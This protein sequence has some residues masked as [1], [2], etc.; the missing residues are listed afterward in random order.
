MISNELFR[1]GSRILKLRISLEI[2]AFDQTGS[3]RQSSIMTLRRMADILRQC[4]SINRGKAY[5]NLEK[6]NE[7]IRDLSLAI[8][9]DNSL[10]NA[11]RNRSTAYFKTQQWEK[12][13]ADAEK[14]LSKDPSWNEGYLIRGTSQYQL[15]NYEAAIEDLKKAE[16]RSAGDENSQ[17]FIADSY[18]ALEDF[19][20]AGIYFDKVV[21]ENADD[22]EAWEKL[23]ISLYKNGQYANAV[24]ALDKCNTTEALGY[25]GMGLYQTGK[26]EES[27]KILNKI[28]TTDFEDVD[29]FRFLA[30]MQ[31]NKELYSQAMSSYSKIIKR[32]PES[33]EAYIGRARAN[34]GLA[35]AVSVHEDLQTAMKLD[36]SPSTRRTCGLIYFDAENFT[37]VVNTLI[38]LEN[39]DEKVNNALAIS[40]Y[41]EQRFKESIPYYEALKDKRGQTLSLAIAYYTT[42]DMA[43]AFKWFRKTEAEIS[44]PSDYTTF[45]AHAAF[46]QKQFAKALSL[47]EGKSSD[48]PKVARMRALSAYELK[49]FDLALEE[50]KKAVLDSA[51]ARVGG[52]SAHKLGKS[53]DVIAFL[54]DQSA[55]IEILEPLASAYILTSQLPSAIDSYT[56]LIALNSESAQYYTSRGELYVELEQTDAAIKDLGKALEINPSLKDA[57][58][59]RGRLAFE[60]EQYEIAIEDL[61]IVKDQDK[62]G[63][64]YYMLGMAY[65][66]SGEKGTAIPALLKADD[67]GFRNVELT[68]ILGTY[69]FD[70][71]EYE[72]AADR[73]THAIQNGNDDPS[74][75][76]MRGRSYYALENYEMAVGDFE[77]IEADTYELAYEYGHSLY[78][79]KNFDKASSLLKKATVLNPNDADAFYYL[80]NAK[81]RLESFKDA[82]KAYESAATNGMSTA[83]LFNNLGKS[84][85]KLDD[86][87]GSLPYFGKAL[88]IDP[89]FEKARLNRGQ[90]YFELNKYEE[91]IDDL[92]E[93]DETEYPEIN[94]MLGESFFQA[95]RLS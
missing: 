4:Y 71:A 86:K 49:Q 45:Y 36:S 68:T 9:T 11:F 35:V 46:E 77:K 54:K 29:A 78:Q 33:V 7:A 16:V 31:I 83:I 38:P 59:L 26:S 85:Y 62:D 74:L 20:S 43:N 58:L 60:L 22:L 17:K 75:R 92:L 18:Y 14:T 30:S 70:T 76:L 79:L 6:Y 40:L 80:G 39:K 72:K 19:K 41:N 8:D 55:S 2:F 12:A 42:D 51:I 27:F 95:E 67:R 94:P 37:Q 84:Y 48:S 87:E 73:L 90:A 15:K 61:E 1:L 13:L 64:L 34:L 69:F 65:Y 56:R 10:T 25:L 52:F 23:G 93:L 81:F 66:E 3:S 57:R 44:I 28:A 47:T 82:I 91:T 53:E 5:L 88:S 63:S 89:A 24:T 50:A 32:E 21:R